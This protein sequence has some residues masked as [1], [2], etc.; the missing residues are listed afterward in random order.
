M[1]TV[2]PRSQ[3]ET[4]AGACL[5]LGNEVADADGFVS[6]RSLLHRFDADLVL[7][8]L[9]VEAML[10]AS[11]DAAKDPRG[12]AARWLL[13]VDSEKY[14]FPH[15]AL[16]GESSTAPLPARFRNTIAHELTHSLAYRAKEFGVKLTL[17]T[18][19]DK[20]KSSA[21][22]EEIEQHTEKLSPLLL[23]SQR[24]I[25]QRFPST[26]EW[27]TPDAL[28]EA[29]RAWGVSRFV[30]IQ[31]L[32]LMRA[33]EDRLAERRCFNNVAVGV[34]SWARDGS[35][36]LNGWP[37]FA[38]FANNEAPAFIHALVRAKSMA[39]S[40]LTGEPSF[41]LN[42]GDVHALTMDVAAGT[43]RSPEWSRLRIEFALESTERKAGGMFFFVARALT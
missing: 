28:A 24:A 4:W 31:R 8:P 37:L 34:G 30:L 38:K 19:S 2:L 32:N 36:V 41:A 3:V 5:A 20:K 39:A 14:T 35:A 26:L 27:L 43:E 6:V 11:T 12:D 22:V 7:R 25:A 13:L 10:C 23:V 1:T 15:E 33:L 40:T 18:T 21:V 16:D 9:L 29:R 42:G 17:P